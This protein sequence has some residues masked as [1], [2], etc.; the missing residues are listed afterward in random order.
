MCMCVY[1]NFIC[2]LWHVARGMLSSDIRKP[3]SFLSQCLVS[4]LRFRVHVRHDGVRPKLTA[5]KEGGGGVVWKGLS[6]ASA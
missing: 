3:W 1:A 6:V 5:C 4:C 2:E